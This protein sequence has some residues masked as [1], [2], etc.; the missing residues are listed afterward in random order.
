MVERQN[1]VRGAAAW[2]ERWRQLSGKE[3][4][5]FIKLSAVILLGALLMSMADRLESG[6]AQ[7]QPEQAAQTAQAAA[8]DGVYAAERELEQRLAE[9]LRQ[10]KGAGTVTVALMFAES[11]AAVYAT[12][13][14]STISA[15]DG[16]DGGSESSSSAAESVAV[17]ADEPLLINRYQPRVQGVVIV[18]SGAGSAV[19]RERLYAAAC[20]L[21]QLTADRVAVLE[22]EE[23][24]QS[25][26]VNEK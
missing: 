23:D 17:I 3:K 25:D 24:L 18:A 10:V 5:L 8:A 12:D 22:G 15:S 1:K 14:D 4:G 19:V 21:L 11:G 9:L 26:N 2:R 16:G 13:I 6:T 20:S 7:P